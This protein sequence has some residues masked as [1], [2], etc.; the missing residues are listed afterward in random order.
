MRIP[1]PSSKDPSTGFTLIEA[2]VVLIIAAV[3][4]AIAAPSWFTFMSRRRVDAVTDDLL[5][6]LKRSQQRAIKE[7]TTVELEL[8][9]DP[10]PTGGGTLPLVTSRGVDIFLGESDSL[11]PGAVQLEFLFDNTPLPQPQ[12]ISFNHR[13]IPLID[14]DGDGVNENVPYVIN[15]SAGNGPRKCVIVATLLGTIKTARAGQCDNV[16]P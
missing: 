8:S 1:R 12:L 7:R 5:Q 14:T 11:R 16:A 15:V 13:G 4:A 10:D 9:N 2:L 3:L 6:T